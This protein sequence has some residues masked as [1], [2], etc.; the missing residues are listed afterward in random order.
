MELQLLL[1][2][3]KTTYKNL[4]WQLDEEYAGSDIIV[5]RFP[6]NVPIVLLNSFAKKLT[7]DIIY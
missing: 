7:Y 4:A 6:V 1:K 5:F 3:L 2:Q